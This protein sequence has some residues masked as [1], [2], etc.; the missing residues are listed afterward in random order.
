MLWITECKNTE[1]TG[2]PDKPEDGIAAMPDGKKIRLDISKVSMGHRKMCPYC[3]CPEVFHTGIPDNAEDV[4]ILRKEYNRRH[5]H[6]PGF[7]PSVE[8]I[9]DPNDPT[10]TIPKPVES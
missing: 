7:T 4:G 2:N 6:E 3:E 5:M 9:R 8:Y 1:C 10:K